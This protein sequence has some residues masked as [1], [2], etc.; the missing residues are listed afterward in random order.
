MATRGHY[1]GFLKPGA[2]APIAVQFPDEGSTPDSTISV[3][4]SESTNKSPSQDF[5]FAFCKVPRLSFA[6]R[7]PRLTIAMIGL[8]LLAI[9]VNAEVDCL[10][11]AGFHWN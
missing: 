1:L 6:E 5:G 2:P 8:G 11:S 7:F 10:R 3:P 9:S 4:E